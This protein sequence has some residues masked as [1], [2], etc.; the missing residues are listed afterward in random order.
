M[1]DNRSDFSGENI[2]DEVSDMDSYEMN[3]H[4]EESESVG[5]EESYEETREMDSVRADNSERG[6]MSRDE[7]ADMNNADDMEK[8]RAMDSLAA[9]APVEQETPVQIQNPVKK[10]RR[11]NKKINHTRTM[12]Q[13]FLGAVLSVTALVLG[14]VLS[15]K[16]INAVI[17]ITGMTKK[18]VEVDFEITE[19]MGLDNI[20]DGLHEKGIINDP[21]LMK[22][23]IKLTKKD[24]GFLNGPHTVNSNMSYNNILAALRTEK[25]FTNLVTVTI[26]EGLTITE[27]GKLLE[28]N[29]VCRAVD[30]EEYVKTKQIEYVKQGS[31]RLFNMEGYLFPDTYEFYEIDYL[32]K[33][34]KYNTKTW[35]KIAAEKMFENFEDKI[36][37]KLRSR[38][39]ELGLTLDQTITL[40]SVIQWEG[41]AEDNMKMI[42]SV[43]HN[44]LDDPETYPKLES[45]AVLKYIDDSI[46][47]HITASNKA[48]MEKLELLYDT[49]E[50]IGLPEGP[51]N[52]P[53]LDAIRAALYP[54]ETDY[55]YFLVA[56]DGTF[57]WA[58]TYEQHQAN[59]EQAGL[60][61]EE[62]PEE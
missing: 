3:P 53:G 30:F 41:N 8:T 10:R 38:M 45:D 21:K 43:F 39:D 59:I 46:K 18:H 14:V 23:Y 31:A 1:N 58:Q 34:P 19:E 7:F 27:I 26:P 54:D 9:D 51:V 35:A 28:E 15:I 55:Y 62:N 6:I 25:E 5:E 17:D 44:R 56:K 60:N 50:C 49:Y 47:T 13:V 48:E 36:T 16:V 20:I 37:K 42:S 40:A 33:N 32:K 2:S 52:N 57:Y 11:K 22:T 29:Y 61:D 4:F 12:G 24:T